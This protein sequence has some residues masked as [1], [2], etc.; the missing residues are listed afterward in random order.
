MTIWVRY[1][2]GRA[3]L[4][5]GTDSTD[6]VREIGPTP[7]PFDRIALARV[8]AD[9]DLEIVEAPTRAVGGPPPASPPTAAPSEP[10][11]L[12]SSESEPAGLF[13]PRRSRRRGR[14]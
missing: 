12:P 3:V 8:E 10:S 2:R 11:P 5:D 7:V 13:G 6:P 9:P 4:R 1:L 14:R